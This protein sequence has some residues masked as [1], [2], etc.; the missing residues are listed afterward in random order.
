MIKVKIANPRDIRMGSPYLVGEAHVEGDWQ[1]KLPRALYQDLVAHSPDGDLAVMVQLQTTMSTGESGLAFQLLILDAADR[2]MFV[3]PLHDGGCKSLRIIDR[4]KVECDVWH[5]GSG[6]GSYSLLIA[7][8]FSECEATPLVL[9]GWKV[10]DEERMAL[11]YEVPQRDQALAITGSNGVVVLSNKRKPR[12]ELDLDASGRRVHPV[13]PYFDPTIRYA[14]LL[15][16]KDGYLVI[17]LESLKYA[18]MPLARADEF[19]FEDDEVSRIYLVPKK[20]GGLLSKIFAPRGRRIFP[21][22]LN[23]DSKMKF[24]K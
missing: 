6:R 15:S 3:S 24:V 4:R 13:Q 8:Q 9:R 18:W 23:W 11:L 1:P 2:K 21:D 10:P 14:F 12:I 19:K 16:E 20:Q 5:H 7:D 17:D 22:K